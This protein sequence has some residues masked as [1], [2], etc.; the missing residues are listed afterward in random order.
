MRH[1]VVILS[2]FLA[3]APA[4]FPA[5]LQVGGAH[6]LTFRDVDGND[7]STNDG[8]VTI[9]TVITRADE[10]KARQVADLI[11]D[12]YVGDEKFR[13]ITLVNFERKIASPF[14]G[15]TRAIIRTRLAAEARELKRDYLAKKILRDPRRDIHVI[16]DFDGSAIERLGL[17][18]R[19][20]GIA[21]FIFNGAGKLVARW[22]GVPSP[23]A[24]SGALAS[25]R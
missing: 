15:L 21:V 18:G 14:Q 3:L 19:G 7:L 10:D 6:V 16:A 17:S 13:Y 9:V 23:G 12:R 5:P 8:R 25:A 4:V 1:R 2:L 24:I 11:P 20:Q 22:S